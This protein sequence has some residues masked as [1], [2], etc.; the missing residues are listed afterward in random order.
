VRLAER[1]FLT[2]VNLRL[3]VIGRTDPGRFTLGGPDP[4]RLPRTPNTV[5]RSRERTALWLGPDEW[6]LLAP[7]WTADQ[8]TGELRAALRTAT[9]DQLVSAVTDVSA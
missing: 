6:L 3:R 9:A 5:C 2:Q 1:P 8:L 4:L 7:E